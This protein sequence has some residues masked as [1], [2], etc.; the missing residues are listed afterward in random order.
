MCQC[1][2]AA[3]LQPSYTF[4][5]MS[6]ADTRSR[7]EELD[8]LYEELREFSVTFEPEDFSGEEAERIVK[9]GEAIRRLGGSIKL[10]ATARVDETGEYKRRG[11]R[12]ASKWLANQTGEPEGKSNA[13]LKA[14]KASE[15]HPVLNDALRN[16]DVPV[17]RAEQITKAADQCPEEAKNL[18]EA[19]KEQNHDEFKNTCDRV[20]FG[21]RS[22]EDE[23]ERHERMRKARQCRMWTDQEGFGCVY[24]KLAVDASRY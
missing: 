9:R 13:E 1:A 2:T 5:D 17:E 6:I 21:S 14:L 8:H 12:S 20:Q 22:T 3:L 18:V 23:V 19:S 10:R 24:A 4:T 11:H 7:L 15:R 16:G